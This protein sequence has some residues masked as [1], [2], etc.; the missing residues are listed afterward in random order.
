MDHRRPQAGLKM[1]PKPTQFAINKNSNY[2][3]KAS[4]KATFRKHLD[5]YLHQGSLH[6]LRYIGERTITWFER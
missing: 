5:Q 3:R 1:P 6:G 2:N 4:E